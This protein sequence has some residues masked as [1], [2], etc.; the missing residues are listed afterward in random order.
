MR[1]L[2]RCS[3]VEREFYSKGDFFFAKFFAANSNSK[4]TNNLRVECVENEFKLGKAYFID[5]TEAPEDE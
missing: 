2:V 5:I 3:S 4:L 1:T